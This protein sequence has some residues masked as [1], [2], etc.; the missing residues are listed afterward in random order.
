MRI[1]WIKKIKGK[2]K[3]EEILDYFLYQTVF[4][5]QNQID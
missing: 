2:R 1:E 5:I 4:T 3:Y